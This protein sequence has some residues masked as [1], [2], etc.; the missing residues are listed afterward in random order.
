MKLKPVR[1]F[2]G[3]NRSKY[4]SKTVWLRWEPTVLKTQKAE[5]R[6]RE[7]GGAG[8]TEGW[9]RGRT[10]ETGRKEFQRQKSQWD[11]EIWEAE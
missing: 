8:D 3:E 7:A 11:W 1:D 9:L 2:D 4:H 6:K 5:L 10:M